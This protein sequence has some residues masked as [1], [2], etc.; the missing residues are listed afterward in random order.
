MSHFLDAVYNMNQAR[1]GRYLRDGMDPNGSAQRG[2]YKAVHLAA[3]NDDLS[4]MKLL[5]S[6]GAFIDEQDGKN[7]PTPLH[8]AA[9]KNNVPMT[10]Y[11]LKKKAR[12]DILSDT[13]PQFLNGSPASVAVREHSLEV[14]DLLREAGA[15]IDLEVYR[16]LSR[17][18]LYDH[19]EIDD[20]YYYVEAQQ[21]RKMHR[22]QQ[23]C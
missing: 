9:A 20:S 4:T 10:Q 19:P 15:T 6:H 1:V 8:I 17:R 3:I 12:L 23:R 13:F 14:L 2:T 16:T 11:L 22:G 5:V 18:I 21:L 7:G